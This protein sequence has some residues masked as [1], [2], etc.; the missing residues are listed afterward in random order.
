MYSASVLKV[1]STTAESDCS[2]FLRSGRDDGG[3]SVLGAGPSGSLAIYVRWR[4]LVLAPFSV[5][6]SP[7]PLLVRLV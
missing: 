5:V 6:L 7:P 2:M 3:S 1:L 4:A